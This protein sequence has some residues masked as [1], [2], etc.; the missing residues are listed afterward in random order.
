MGKA[1]HTPGPWHLVKRGPGFYVMAGAYSVAQLTTRK[2]DA[3]LMA[4]AP[5]LL[6]AVQSLLGCCELNL[7]EMEDDTR[8]AIGEAETAVA[9]CATCE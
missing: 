5:K 2:E 6:A 7:D 4:A 1:T 9:A 8:E 3:M